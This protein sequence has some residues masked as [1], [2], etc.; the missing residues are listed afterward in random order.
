MTLPTL[1]NVLD[2]GDQRGSLAG[3]TEVD[4]IIAARRE[5]FRD[6]LDVVSEGPDRIPVPGPF[7]IRLV[8]GGPWVPARITYGPTVDPE[9]G[10]TLDR[11]PLWEAVVLGKR[12]AE[13]SPCPQT[14]GAVSVAARGNPVTETEYD[15][16]MRLHAWAVDHDR[17]HPA[18]APREPIDFLKS[19]TPF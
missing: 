5:L 11:S 15:Y 16:L 12:V 13:P 6:L 19:R 1:V 4:D 10:E 18:A 3:M 7:R 8:S 17:W 2:S 9:T 14:A